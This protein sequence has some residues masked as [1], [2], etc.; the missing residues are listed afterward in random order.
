MWRLDLNAT[1]K[2]PLPNPVLWT[3]SGLGS[4]TKSLSSRSTARTSWLGTRHRATTLCAS[5]ISSA[6]SWLPVCG[7]ARVPGDGVAHQRVPLIYDEFLQLG[8]EKSQLPSFRGIGR[9]SHD[10]SKVLFFKRSRE[11]ESYMPSQP[12]RSLWAMSAAQEN[13]RHSRYLARRRTV[14]DAQFS[15]FSAARS[16]FQAPVSGRQFSISVF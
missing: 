11:F 13:A 16:Q 8:R 7:Y 14:S 15:R 6:A 10:I 2:D 4:M 12:V 3:G 5:S 1:G 9:N